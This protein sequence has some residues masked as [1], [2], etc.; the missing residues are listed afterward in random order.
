MIKRKNVYQHIAENNWKIFGLVCLFPIALTAFIY[1]A[2]VL[3][4]ILSAQ[5]PQE[6]KDIMA[7]FWQTIPFILLLCTGLTI[8]S[9]LM[10]DKMML[11][12][13][14]A[15]LCQD[16]EEHLKVRRAV[17]NIA[18]AAG[19]PTPKVYLINDDSLNAFATGFSPQTASIA[20]TTG[21]VKKLKPLELDAVIAHEM[22]HIKNR[23]IRLN[24]YVITGIGIIGMFGEILIRQCG[25]SSNSRNK[26]ENG[27]QGIFLIIG[28]SL[29]LFRYFIAPFIHMAISRKQEF[30]ADATGSFF[31]RNP[32]ALASALQKI[33]LDPRVE[34]LDNSQ[35]MAAV[36]IYNPLKKVARLLDTH[37]PVEERIIRLQSML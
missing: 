34:A 18:L 21:I 3:F 19:L 32:G 30:Q 20:L 6:A 22:A 36:C 2:F 5:S 35:Q 1:L 29:L 23:D 9:C 26:N 15:H 7:V 28:L 27:V 25:R 17:E 11:S 24:M 4:S 33:S 16:N 12:F 13:A 10:G 8:L 37:P 14:G 31:T